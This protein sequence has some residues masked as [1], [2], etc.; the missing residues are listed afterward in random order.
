M[1]IGVQTW[2]RYKLSSVHEMALLHEGCHKE[3]RQ[4]QVATDKIQK[5]LSIKTA[6]LMQQASPAKDTAPA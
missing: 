6:Y 2:V 5:H 4:M 1:W 3:P